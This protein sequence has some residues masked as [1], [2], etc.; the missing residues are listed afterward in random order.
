MSKLIVEVCQIEEVNPHPNA[1]RLEVC[2]VKGWNVII[3]K[4]QFQPGQLCVYFPPDVV[5][6]PSLANGPNDEVPGRLDAMKYLHQLPKNE[7]GSR[8]EGGRVTACRLRGQVS[9]GIIMEIDPAKG[10]NPEWV[11]G[12]DVAEHFGV[13]KF[14]PPVETTDGEAE[15]PNTRFYK[16]TSIQHLG[17]YPLA[18]SDGTEIVITEKIHG[19]NA[20]VGLVLENDDAGI[21]KWTWMAGSHDVRRRE[22]VRSETRFRVEELIEK[23]IIPPAKDYDLHVG[24]II[25]DAGRFWQVEQLIDQ[26]RPLPE[27]PPRPWYIRILEAIGIIKKLPT[28]EVIKKVQCFEVSKSAQ[29]ETGLEETAVQGYHTVYKKS[30]FWLILDEQIRNLIQHV[31]SYFEWPEPKHSV[32]LYGEIFGGGVQDMKYGMSNSRDFRVFDLAI[33]NQYV[34][35]QD[36]KLL[37]TQFG[38]KGVPILYQGPFSKAVVEQHTTGTTTL[39]SKEEAGPFSGREGVVVKP[40]VEVPY[41]PV[42]NG[43]R[44]LKSVS[45]DYLARRDGTEFH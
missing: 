13:T 29:P 16:Y 24:S 14:E 26:I 6:P 20:R 11:V 35:L 39:C 43:R 27:P 41:C 18:I 33:N 42:L 37:L 19:K 36:L 21:A 22:W 1:D 3:K 40:V 45:A 32:I 38:I 15:K 23:G 7:D 8:P 25:D 4:G 30:E 31:V 44:I 9:Y 10:D 12:T 2:R 5:M 28:E 17:N 34:N